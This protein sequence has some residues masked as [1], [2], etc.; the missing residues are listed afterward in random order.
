M[1]ETLLG[2]SSSPGVL[3]FRPSSNHPCTF[4]LFNRNSGE[5]D[6]KNPDHDLKAFQRVQFMLFTC[7]CESPALS[8]LIY[9]SLSLSDL[10]F[11]P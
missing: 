8:P 4:S 7:L 9:S 11:Q 2:P 3:T 5:G 1:L 10:R 6:Y